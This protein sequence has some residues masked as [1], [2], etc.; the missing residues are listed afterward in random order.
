MVDLTNFVLIFKKK[1]I[2]LLLQR[3]SINVKIDRNK[4]V[5]DLCFVMEA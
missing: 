5:F 1:N 2:S 4:I 3:F